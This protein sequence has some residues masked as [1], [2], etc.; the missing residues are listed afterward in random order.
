MN[1]KLSQIEKNLKLKYRFDNDG[2][3]RASAGASMAGGGGDGSQFGQPRNRE[4]ER[5]VDELHRYNSVLLRENGNLKT[6]IKVRSGNPGNG[7]IR[8]SSV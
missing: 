3:A 8:S 2:S 6:K 1:T 4:N 5:L 7:G